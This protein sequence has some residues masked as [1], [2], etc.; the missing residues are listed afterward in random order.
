VDNSTLVARPAVDAARATKKVATLP[1]RAIVQIV[2][3]PECCSD[4]RGRISASF[5]CDLPQ[6]PSLVAGNGFEFAWT[7]PGRWMAIGDGA[8]ETCMAQLST[9]LADT[10]SRVDVSDA[11][12]T[13]R[14]NGPDATG[15][16]MKLVPIDLEPSA[17]PSSA[18]ALTHIAHVAVIIMKR[19]PGPVFDVLI[20]RSFAATIVGW[21]EHA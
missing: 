8:P 2:C 1:D 4:L 9:A 16:L 3:A 6:K 21:I 10:A 17:F 15:A 14:L 12:A 11:Y 20:P 18:V 5:G 7:G 19:G 13:F